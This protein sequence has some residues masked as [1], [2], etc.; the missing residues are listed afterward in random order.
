MFIERGK[1]SPCEKF[2]EFDVT[3]R[4]NRF[5][6][7]QFAPILL[8]RAILN[9]NNSTRHKHVNEHMKQLIRRE[10]LE[11]LFDKFLH[12]HILQQG[13]SDAILQKEKAWYTEYKLLS[14]IGGCLGMFLGNSVLDLLM[15]ALR[16][17]W[18]YSLLT[19]HKCSTKP[20]FHP[21]I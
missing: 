3:T 16:R 9:T 8:S 13:D 14:N 5:P 21:P 15:T 4:S 6:T 19:F 2:L 17:T 11:N 12:V 20:T 7:A 18:Q 1:P 10:P